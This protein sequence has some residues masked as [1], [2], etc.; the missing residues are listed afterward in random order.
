MT[1]EEKQ[2]VYNLLK[3]ASSWSLG[4]SSPAFEEAVSFEDDAIA[5]KAQEPELPPR[6]QAA[7]PEAHEQAPCGTAIQTAPQRRTLEAVYAKVA[8]CQNCIL[9]RTRIHTVPGEGVHR[10]CVMVIG[11]GPGE[12]EDKS[13]RPFVGRA[14]QLLDKMLASIGLG[15]SANCYIAN[16]VKCRPP[17]NRTPMPDEAAACAGYLQA[18][19][20]LLAPRF[21][22]AMGRTAVQN[23]LQTSEGINALRGK[24]REYNAGS[25]TIPLMATY[26]PSALLRDESLKRP[27]WDDLKSFR[28]RL[29]QEIPGYSE[30]FYAEH[31]SQI[32]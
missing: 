11:E 9:G 10:P 18:Q 32:H 22:L 30:P 19:I 8:S 21:I 26:H 16:I 20:H 2:A 12:E 6:T 17:R 13:G 5:C 24:W 31:N 4:Y 28:A 14:G 15:R 1:A 3:T 27:A 29:L 23:L 7:A 25:E